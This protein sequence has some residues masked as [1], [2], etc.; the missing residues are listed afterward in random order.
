[1]KPTLE[2]TVN[3]ENSASIEK[4]ESRQKRKRGTVD[5]SELDKELKKELAV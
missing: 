3:P 4:N 1:M 2:T 5:Y